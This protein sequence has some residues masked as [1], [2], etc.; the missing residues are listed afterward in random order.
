MVRRCEDYFRA[1][2]SGD[3][4]YSTGLP[5][6]H[7]HVAQRY[8][9]NQT[10][11]SCVRQQAHRWAAE[12]AVKHA[13]T[14]RAYLHENRERIRVRSLEW[15]YA[16]KDRC[17]KRQKFW[18]EQ[19]RERLRRAERER[20]RTN[21]EREVAYRKKSYQNNA[22]K[23]KALS[24]QYRKDNPDRVWAIRFPEKARV[25]RKRWSEKESSKP[26]MKAASNR[27]RVRKGG[28]GGTISGSDIKRLTE[29]QG[30]RCAYCQKK[31]KLTLDHIVALAN[32]GAH[33]S[34]NAQ[35]L[36]GSCN[37]KKSAK[38]PLDYARQIG[39]LL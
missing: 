20:R 9:S 36:C 28:G 1:K 38:D 15:Y 11:V 33:E 35:M 21:P 14:V 32:G 34:R 5:C 39:L 4:F 23:R 7:G 25:S 29:M 12:N 6:I 24:R 37:S 31:T 8:T 2:A 10:C 18:R 13:E 22:E 30:G 16:N 26:I 3:R 17:R 27:R 19:N